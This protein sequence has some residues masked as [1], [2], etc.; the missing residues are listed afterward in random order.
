MDENG[1]GNEHKREN[2]G[3]MEEGK[4]IPRVKHDTVH[5]YMMVEVEVVERVDGR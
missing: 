4:Q 5:K 3:R 1:E 2:G